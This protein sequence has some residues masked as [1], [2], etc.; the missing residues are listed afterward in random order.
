[1]RKE[2]EKGWKQ[3][4]RDM[5]STADEVRG[6]E[7][8]MEGEMNF[9]FNHDPWLD[10]GLEFLYT[11]LRD[12]QDDLGIEVKVDNLGVTVIPSN[13]EDFFQEFGRL[14]EGIRS[15]LVVKVEDKKTGERKE[16]KKDFI[17]IQEGK[18]LGGIVAFKEDIYNT[19]KSK[20]VVN[21][22]FDLIKSD[23][24]NCCILCGERF[25]KPYK[26]LQQA[27]YPFVTK[28]KSLTGVRS[29]KDGDVYSFREYFTNLCPRC[30][31]LG[32]LVWADDGLVYRTFPRGKSFLF[33]PN[34]KTLEELFEFKQSYR[35]ILNNSGRYSN[36]RVHRGADDVENTPGEYSTLLCFYEKFLNEIEGDG[37]LT[38]EWN[39]AHIPLGTV[40]NVKYDTVVLSE[41][42]IETLRNVIRGDNDISIYSE[43]MKKVFFFNDKPKGSPVDFDI[44]RTIQENLSKAFLTDDF[45]KFARELLPRKGG[46]VGFSKETRDYL[47][48]LIYIWRWKKMG[49]PKEELDTLK[50]VGNIIA[51]ASSK[52]LSLLYK[53]DK[54]RN[55]ED[56]WSVLREI[57][58]KTLGFK[59][60]ERSKIKPTALDGLI[61]LVKTYEDKWKEIRDLLV[62]YSSMYYSIKTRKGG[63]K[64]E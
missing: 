47:E 56:F 13:T 16:I 45:R 28:I 34:H 37:Y 50:S 8:E 52:N 51:I 10:N 19:D 17:L 30:Y 36:I 41:F 20:K 61:Q 58:R 23:G 2:V 5:E 57:S 6:D 40:K 64:N 54:T 39:V 21:E 32:I 18:K 33:L 11:L 62:V 3:A 4:S 53:L 48:E 26:K 38:N 46:H 12:N 15:N 59:E 43:I 63:D 22:I 27:S 60:D 35:G 24:D 55:L 1:M 49:I 44:T 14:I 25:S 29:Y 42:I 7:V 31:L 9:K